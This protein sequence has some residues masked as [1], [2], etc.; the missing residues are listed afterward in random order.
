MKRPRTRTLVLTGLAV[1]ILGG[2]GGFAL[3]ANS[4]PPS[5]GAHPADVYRLTMS[6][7]GVTGIPPGPT[8][9]VALPD[10]KKISLILDGRDTSDPEG[11][12]SIVVW[13]ESTTAEGQAFTVHTG[14]HVRSN[15]LDITVLHVWNEPMPK[16][17]AVDVKADPTR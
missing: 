4:A 16:N 6:N 14:S 8:A 11:V 13:T 10:G 17:D 15:G 9:W 12:N 7:H 2:G 1:V 3:W 5:L